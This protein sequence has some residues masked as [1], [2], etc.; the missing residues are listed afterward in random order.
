M[1][2]AISDK[3]PVKGSVNLLGAHNGWGKVRI[4]REGNAYKVQYAKNTVTNK[5]DIKTFTVTK[6]SCL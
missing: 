1:G 6:K 3:A 4:T 2:F 5:S